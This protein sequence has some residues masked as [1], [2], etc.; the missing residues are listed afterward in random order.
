MCDFSCKCCEARS[1][2]PPPPVSNK[3]VAP[4]MQRN[5]NHPASTVYKTTAAVTPLIVAEKKPPTA[6]ASPAPPLQIQ[7]ARSRLSTII[8][9][10]VSAATHSGTQ[11]STMTYTPPTADRI[12]SSRGSNKAFFINQRRRGSDAIPDGV[13]ASPHLAPTSPATA[14]NSSKISPKLSDAL[15]REIIWQGYAFQDRPESEKHILGSPKAKSI[16][17][18]SDEVDRSNAAQAIA[19]LPVQAPATNEGPITIEVNG[20]TIYMVS[21]EDEDHT[22][23]KHL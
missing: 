4:D 6:S 3:P 16:R 1:I 17:K 11:T 23:K 22:D 13:T 19:E 10:P 5:D 8:G 9:S 7:T 2:D 12:G 18:V 21:S 15:Q 20:Q 14:Q